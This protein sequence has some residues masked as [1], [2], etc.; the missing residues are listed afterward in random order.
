[1]NVPEVK[2]PEGTSAPEAGPRMPDQS[3]LER[4]AEQ[5]V[6]TAPEQAT[7]K[8]A[9][10]LPKATVTTQPAPPPVVDAEVELD[11]K[12]VYNETDEEARVTK[13]LSLVET[14]GPEYAVRVARHL[15]DNYVLDRMH[16]ELA[17]RFYETLKAKGVVRDE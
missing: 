10:T 7:E 11:A 16:D 14:K 5:A 6:E 4:V 9:E 15:D 17:G 3:P 13:L 1:M 12:S 2:I 8:V